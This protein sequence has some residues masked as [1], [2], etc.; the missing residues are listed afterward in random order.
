MPFK[1]KSVYFIVF[2]C[3]V[4]NPESQ[5]I[6]FKHDEPGEDGLL[7]WLI[8]PEE[9]GDEAFNDRF[10]IKLERSRKSLPDCDKF[11]LIRLNFPLNNESAFSRAS[12]ILSSRFRDLQHPAKIY[13][14]LH[15]TLL[16]DD[17]LQRFQNE[18]QQIDYIRIPTKKLAWML[19]KSIPGAKHHDIIFQLFSCNSIFFSKCFQQEIYKLGF[20][21]CYTI[22]YRD[23]ATA[24]STGMSGGDTFRLMDFGTKS[25]VEKKDGKIS[26]K[27]HSEAQNQP[28]MK[29]LNFSYGD[30][31]VQMGYREAIDTHRH[32]SLERKN[33]FEYEQARINTYYITKVVLNYLGKS[34]VKRRS[35]LP[36]FDAFIRD[37]CEIGQPK[38]E[39]QELPNQLNF[40]YAIVVGLK[41][42][43][44]RLTKRQSLYEAIKLGHI[45]ALLDKISPLVIESSEDIPFAN[46]SSFKK[47]GSDGKFRVILDNPNHFIENTLMHFNLPDF[48]AVYS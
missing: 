6:E 8:S 17:G 44:Q 46:E 35:K 38:L 40:C 7:R 48:S 37:V 39:T 1:F 25:Q 30:T 16:S 2:D 14:N 11:P 22:G 3:C 33:F 23:I 4:L 24:V 9:P 27:H 47:I 5:G 20:R 10:Y 21:N 13:I 18:H 19:W 29:L 32:L 26:Y 12:Q 31:V 41:I 34:T 43:H 42:M 28:D 36:V 15:C 45:D